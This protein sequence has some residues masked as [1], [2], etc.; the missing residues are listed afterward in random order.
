[1]KLDIKKLMNEAL[2]MINESSATMDKFKEILASG[3]EKKLQIFYLFIAYGTEKVPVGID[4]FDGDVM[5]N[6]KM[7]L[8]NMGFAEWLNHTMVV[9]KDDNGNDVSFNFDTINNVEYESESGIDYSN[10]SDSDMLDYLNDDTL[11][12]MFTYSNNYIRFKFP[13]VG[14]VTERFE[15]KKH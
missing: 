3:D 11:S 7:S 14:M 9:L 15:S 1:M 4:S 13:N 8:D 12:I 5:H 6:I 10:M 2:N